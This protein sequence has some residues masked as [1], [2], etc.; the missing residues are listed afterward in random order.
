M[1]G[2]RIER[3]DECSRGVQ[4]L[5]VACDRMLKPRPFAIAEKLE[6]AAAHDVERAGPP[7]RVL[8]EVQELELEALLEVTRRHAGRVEALHQAKRGEKIL[9]PH[10]VLGGHQ[11][12]ELVE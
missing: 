11:F 8:V 5:L 9:C 10:I 1:A 6:M 4:R 7:W 3:P 2:L 12:G